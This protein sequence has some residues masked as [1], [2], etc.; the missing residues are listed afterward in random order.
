MLLTKIPRPHI[1]ALTL[2]TADGDGAHAKKG[3]LLADQLMCVA[4]PHGVR[5]GTHLRF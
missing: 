3:L 4:V 5:T 1:P 2:D